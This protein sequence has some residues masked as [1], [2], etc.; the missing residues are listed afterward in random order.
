M[1]LGSGQKRMIKRTPILHRLPI[2]NKGIGKLAGFGI[3][4]RIEVKTIKDGNGYEFVLDRD[5][6]ENSEKNG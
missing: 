4:K 1:F 5:S 3:A 2:G 6:F